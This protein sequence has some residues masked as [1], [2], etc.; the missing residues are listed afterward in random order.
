MHS[1]LTSPACPYAPER[2]AQFCEAAAPFLAIN[3]VPV[4]IHL[5]LFIPCH[6]DRHLSCFL[7]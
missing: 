1:D 5:N 6:A 3:I 7:L 2:H 4:Q